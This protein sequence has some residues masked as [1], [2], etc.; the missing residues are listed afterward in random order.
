MTSKQQQY[1]TVTV[2]V[3]IVY[4]LGTLL[5]QF[6]QELNQCF[7]PSN[8]KSVV[9]SDTSPSIQKKR[10]SSTKRRQTSKTHQEVPSPAQGTSSGTSEVSCVASG[11]QP[12][13]TTQRKRRTTSRAGTTSQQTKRSRSGRSTASASP[14]QKMK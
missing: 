12:E 10:A 14:Q 7:N 9:P 3:A 11:S 4:T 5:I 6:I 2:V 8:K 13:V 1:D